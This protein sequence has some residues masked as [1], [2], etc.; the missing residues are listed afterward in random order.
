MRASHELPVQILHAG[1]H[2]VFGECSVPRDDLHDGEVRGLI[3]EALIDVQVE[4]CIVEMTVADG[5]VLRILANVDNPLVVATHYNPIGTSRTSCMVRDPGVV[6]SHTCL[7]TPMAMEEIRM[8]V[9]ENAA[10]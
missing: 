1:P 2:L 7:T 4:V 3:G 5:D 8:D 10:H 6:M 9:L